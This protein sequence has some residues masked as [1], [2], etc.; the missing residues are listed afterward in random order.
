MSEYVTKQRR[1]LLAFLTEH[2]DE[3]LTVSQI[4]SALSLE[5]IS[6]SAVYRNIAS[7]T[8]EGKLE[9]SARLGDREV[10]YRYTAAEHCRNKL[11][12]TCKA[13]G[14]TFHMGKDETNQ[15]MS[16]LQGTGFSVD[17]DTSVLYG[18]CSVCS[19]K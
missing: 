3:L 10:Y 6:K 4:A 5:G 14:A 2:A 1:A 17:C 12:M 7:L 11:H 19:G 18:K 8:A 16:L 9:R 13:C 15:L